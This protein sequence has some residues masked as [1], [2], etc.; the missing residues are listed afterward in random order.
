LR[1]LHVLGCGDPHDVASETW[2][3]VVRDL[4]SFSGREQTFR[5]LLFTTGRQC[6]IA[7]AETT[8]RR[9]VRASRVGLDILADTEVGQDQVPDA[10]ARRAVALLGRLSPEHAESVA[11]RVLGGLDTA[12]VAEIIGMSADTV[13]AALHRALRMLAGDADVRELALQSASTA[14]A[15]RTASAVTDT[16]EIPVPPL[17]R[18][19]ALEPDWRV[20]EETS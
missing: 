7:H 18:R 8:S 12:D 13:A 5:R 19:L 1:Y 10:P 2:L 6:A 11:L 3:Q 16:I 17:P 14:G 4:P 20:R 9:P 15:T